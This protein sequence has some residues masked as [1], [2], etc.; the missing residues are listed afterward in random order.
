MIFAMSIL[1]PVKYRLTNLA[2]FIEGGLY[3]QIAKQ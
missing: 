2:I 1:L 3:K